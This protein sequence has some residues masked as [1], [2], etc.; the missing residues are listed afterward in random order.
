[1]PIS[2]ERDDGPADGYDADWQY[3]ESEKL[4]LSHSFSP[5]RNASPPNR[6][7]QPTAND[8]LAALFNPL[9]KSFV[10]SL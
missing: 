3:Y 4:N 8:E 2:R 9:A 7:E 10:L 5:P 1:M 6:R